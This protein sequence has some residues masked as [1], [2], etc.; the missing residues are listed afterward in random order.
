MAN[1]TIAT[2]LLQI[3]AIKLNPANPF[4][5]ASGW[6][7][8]IYCDN[9]KTLS[10]PNVR[11]SICDGFV[12]LIR[13]KYP[14]VEIIAGV[15]TGAIAHGMLVADRMALP[16]IYVRSAPKAHGLSNQIEGDYKPGQKVVVIEDLISTGMSSLAAVEALKS[17]GCKVLGL[18]AIFTYQFAQASE[19]F[20]SADVDFTTLSNYTELIDI[21]VESGYVKQDQLNLLKSWREHPD[22]WGK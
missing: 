12:N 5:W 17:A 19:G 3:N 11:N 18:V 7:S 13:E 4:T 21:A 15:A 20:A 1:K 14:D 22:T 8:P 9:R 6:K 16:F 2:N 10:F